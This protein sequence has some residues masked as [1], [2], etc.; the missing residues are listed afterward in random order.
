[1]NKIKIFGIGAIVLLLVTSLSVTTL[2]R[3]EINP[4]DSFMEEDDIL[5]DYDCASLYAQLEQKEDELSEIDQNINDKNNEIQNLENRIQQLDTQINNLND[6]KADLQSE[7]DTLK[8]ERSAL[9]NELRNLVDD[10]FQIPLRIASINDEI[11][12]IK[13]ISSGEYAQRMIEQLEFERAQLQEEMD[14]LPVRSIEIATQIGF[15]NQK[16]NYVTSKITDLN[17]E[18]NS[19]NN[20][21]SRT[22]TRLVDAR[23]ERSRLNYERD[24]VN[25]EIDALKKKIRE[26][27]H[28]QGN[29][30]P[31][32]DGTGSDDTDCGCQP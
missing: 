10:S 32:N 1:M 18:I 5:D 16:I 11:A 22:N 12:R 13:R 9:I 14:S 4:F 8:T 25:D 30:N 23:M 2:A 26:K 17:T 29:D 19:L 21:R 31:G 27:C 15:I 7:I 3:R 6:D 24:I 20:E 28:S